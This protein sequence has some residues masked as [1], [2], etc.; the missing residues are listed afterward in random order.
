MAR[1]KAKKTTKAKKETTRDKAL[2]LLIAKGRDQGFVTQE[3]ILELFQ[4]AEKTGLPVDK[5]LNYYNNYFHIE[6]SISI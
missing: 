2:K 6:P 5:L 3:E 4:D 1:K